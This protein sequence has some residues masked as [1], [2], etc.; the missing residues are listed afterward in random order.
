MSSEAVK[1][2]AVNG[3]QNKFGMTH[4]ATQREIDNNQQL[5]NAL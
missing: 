4:L 2:F 5:V 3:S 1:C